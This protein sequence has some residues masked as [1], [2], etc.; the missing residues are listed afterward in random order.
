MTVAFGVGC[1]GGGSSNTGVADSCASDPGG[2]SAITPENFV[3]AL[4]QLAQSGQIPAAYAKTT[5]VKSTTLT[6]VPYSSESFVVWNGQTQSY[7]AIGIRQLCTSGANCSDSSAE[8]AAQAF[9]TD[10]G[11]SAVGDFSDDGVSYAAASV[12]TVPV[13]LATDVSSGNNEPVFQS[14]YNGTIYYSVGAQTKDVDLQQAQVQDTALVQKAA[15]ISATFQMDFNSAV[16]LTQLAG[17]IQT[18]QSAANE[19]TPADRA[20]VTTSLLGIA[21][22]TQDEVTQAVQQGSSGDMTGA[23]A[24]IGKISQNIG[25]PETMLRDQILPKLGVNLN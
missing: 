25:M 14:A 5:L 17:R 19:L 16:Q 15:Q 11:A 9:A 7:E 1:N 20:A 4:V 24:L 6:P 22:I 2:C 18:M 13:V 8:A 10:G 23:N 3:S 21:G 12:G